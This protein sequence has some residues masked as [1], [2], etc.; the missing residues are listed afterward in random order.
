MFYKLIHYQVTIKHEKKSEKK[1]KN[2]VVFCHTSTRIS[3]RHT[4]VPSLPDLPPISFPTPP[5]SL[6][7]SP[8]LSSLSHKQIPTGYLFYTWYYKFLYYSLHTSPPCS[9]PTMSIGLFSMSVS[10]LPP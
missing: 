6:S 8:C 3:H 2:F 7:Q 10:P 5:F 1:K 4:C 9:P